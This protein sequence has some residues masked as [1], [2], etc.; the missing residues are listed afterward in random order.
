MSIS[1]KDIRRVFVAFLMIVLVV[2][3][4]LIVKPIVLSIIGGLLLAY[5]FTPVY[6]ITYKLI[7]ERNT[8]AFFMC[9]IVLVL[10]LVPLWIFIP[11]IVEQIFDLFSLTQNIDFSQVVQAIFP[12]S[13]PQF[14][15]QVTTVVIKFV[16]NI[17]SSA[18]EYLIG[19]IQNFPTVLLNLAVVLFVFFFS[20]RDQEALRE[21]ISGI[22]PFR[23]DKESVLVKR[24]K[25]ITSSIIFGYIIVGAIQGLALGAGLWWFDV[26][27]ALTLTILG[28]FAAMLPMVGPWLV[29]I[30]I[31]IFLFI[32]GNTSA[33]I[34]FAIYCT[35]IVSSIDNVL[36]PYIVARKTGTSSVIVLVG[37][38]GGL[39]VFNILGLILGPLILSYLILFLKAY[40]DGT[41][42]DMFSPAE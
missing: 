16:G 4:F 9:L 37:M 27:K 10:I 42:S 12:S 1:N 6:R 34:W 38:I 23:K 2:A 39:F 15:Q 26:P 36:R 14:Q 32:G 22:S 19:F 3:A 11:I 29:W 33:A 7:R 24:F 13:Q 8:S 20:L 17:T 35:V 25:D 41:L 31:A 18:I 5:I 28:M 21:F 40:K 30:P